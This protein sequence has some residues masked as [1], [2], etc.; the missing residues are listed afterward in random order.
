[1]VVRNE[2]D[3]LVGPVTPTE[4]RFSA[5]E[6][7]PHYFIA[8]ATHCGGLTERFVTNVFG[9]INA[10][11]W[12]VWAGLFTAMMCVAILVALVD[13]RFRCAG[14]GMAYYYSFLELFSIFLMESSPRPA[15]GTVKRWLIGMWWL[16]AFVMASAFTGH[17]KA[18]LTMKTEGARLDSVADVVA[19]RHIVP[20]IIRG[21]T[22]VE[23]F[24]KSTDRSQQELWARA[25]RMR[26]V[27][28]A[29]QVFSRETFDKVLAGKAVV[30]L[31]H[32]L[33]YHA[34][35]SLYETPPSGEFYLARESVAFLMMGMFQNRGLDPRLRRALH[36]RSRW[37]TE[38]GLPEKFRLD[39][40]ARSIRHSR[41]DSRFHQMSV[42]DVSGL[43]YLYLVGMGAATVAVLVERMVHSSMSKCRRRNRSLS[44]N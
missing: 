4:D 11:D 43:F 27:L 30:F 16:A 29:K 37:I 2:C 28:S 32:T 36:V 19:K 25:K 20:V 33:F 42:D 44:S 9:Y 21:S 24:Q 38:S 39:T 13:N 35:A 26:S 6:P 34:V 40:I 3:I 7:L 12:E 17:M 14:F 15:K 10:F 8:V 31:E 41:H 23:L 1:M 5:L 22:Y 18:S